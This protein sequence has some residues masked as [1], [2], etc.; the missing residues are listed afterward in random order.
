MQGSVL[1]A[2]RGEIA[3]RVIRTATGLGLRT[4]AIYTD[5]DAGAPH[6][7]E[8]DLA[9]CVDSYLSIDEVVAA[10]VASGAGALH[11][12]YGFLSERADL[13]RACA[14]AGIVFVGPSPEAIDA[15]GDKV[16]AKATAAAVGLPVLATTSPD[17]DVSALV[18]PVLVKAAAGGG[19]RGMRVVEQPE[20][21]PAAVAA[22]RREALA[23]FGDAT[24]F[25]EPYV[26]ASRHVEV[27]VIAD[28]H[29]AVLHLGERECSLQ[30]RHQKVVEEAPSPVVDPPLRERLGQSA[31]ALARAAGYEGAGTVE[32]LL[33]AAD[34]SRFWF[35]EM[36]ARLQVEHPVTELVTGLDLV[37]LQLRVAFGE[38]L[39]LAQADV[40]LSGWAVE[41]R[42]VAEDAAAGYLPAIG[43]VVAYREPAGVGVRVDSGIERGSVV[44]TAYDSLL[45][46]VVA[47]GPTR[48]VALARLDRALA[49]TTILGVTTT[50]A[51]LRS[52]L[53]SDEVRTATFDTGTLGR[54]P[55]SLPVASNEEVAGAGAAVLALLAHEAGNDGWRHA[56]DRA[57]YR[58]RLAVDGGVG[59]DL[60]VAHGERACRVDEERYRVAGRTWTAVQAGDDL[61]LGVDGGA[62]VISRSLA[63]STTRAV[64]SGDLRAPMPGVVLLVPVAVGD[65]VRAG[66]TVLVIESMKLELAVTAPADGVV[67]VVHVSVGETVS[68]DQPLAH[69]EV[70]G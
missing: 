46:K 57:P 48:A 43:T 16:R 64:A 51:H 41:A 55:D 39:P 23:G 30:R 15:V 54:L 31:C 11:P 18:F 69:V 9:V 70:E 25:L 62:W 68:R 36:N 60:L 28:R 2:N 35:L 26:R 59:A 6:V 66:E 34:P 12:G 38:P 10:A 32:F 47:H 53:A 19:G 21:L 14:A 67:T 42:V 20:D 63:G 4:I 24:V 37:E 44:T 29:G 3:R 61:H 65:R 49:G 50:V 58:F 22:A 1:I 45:A 33:D 40:V 5:L 17:D 56:G 27:Q 8:A 13:A 52:V 7:R